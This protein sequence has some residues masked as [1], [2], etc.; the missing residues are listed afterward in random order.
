MPHRVRVPSQ[1][2]SIRRIQPRRKP[3]SAKSLARP[4]AISANLDSQRTSFRG[5]PI[6][7]IFK[8]L[9]LAVPEFLLGLSFTLVF[10]ELPEVYAKRMEVAGYARVTW[11]SMLISL[12]LAI[13][14]RPRL[15]NWCG[16]LISSRWMSRRISSRIKSKLQERRPLFDSLSSSAA[17]IMLFVC[18]LV[19][20]AFPMIAS[21]GSA[22]WRTL[23]S[24]FVI[25]SVILWIPYFFACFFASA[26][27]AV[28][29]VSTGHHLRGKRTGST[30]KA[31][32]GLPT[33]GSGVLV[34]FV[35]WC[36][37]GDSSIDSGTWLMLAAIPCFLAAPIPTFN[38]A[39]R[40]IGT[41]G[42]ESVG[43]STIPIG[44]TKTTR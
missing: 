34:G 28:C 15:R 21:L 9:I 23:H 14:T 29:L 39:S 1:P 16:L 7:R 43:A 44:R 17:S 40:A 19:I 8:A 20:I 36:A 38:S 25:P 13:I 4:N 18:G 2:P 24:Q 32:L 26:P 10:C 41:W 33:F 30:S 5:W 27:L 31:N 3:N 37:F 12:P 6:R 11:A 22:S 42:S 35:I